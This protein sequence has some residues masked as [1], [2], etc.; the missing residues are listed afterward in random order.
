MIKLTLNNPNGQNE[1]IDLSK[2]DIYSLLE[3]FRD[4][5]IE[6][7]PFEYKVGEARQ[8]SSSVSIH[9]DSDMG[10]AVISLLSDRERIYDV[11]ILEHGLTH[12]RDELKEE[13]EQNLLNEQYGSTEEL[14]DD[15]RRMTIELAP[16][17]MS[18]FCPLEG[19]MRDDEDGYYYET[20][21]YTLLANSDSIEEYLK[22]EQSPEVSM[23]EYVGEHAELG[24]KLI[25][26]EWGV[27]EISGTL[28]GR[29]DCYLTE[30]LS[31]EETERLRDAITGQNSDGLGE[32]F[33]QRDIPTDEGDLNVSFWNCKGNYFLYTQDEMDEYLSQQ[34]GMKFGGS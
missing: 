23:A 33:E 32:G 1:T 17:K 16:E 4:N 14:F 8:E 3:R 21:N 6:G 18:F 11:W 7:S 10:N 22:R 26:A 12:V 30:P 2:H 25:F 24:D 31:I 29:I 19:N 27:E 20:D 15:V 5:G 28:Y 34:N 9:S 13:V